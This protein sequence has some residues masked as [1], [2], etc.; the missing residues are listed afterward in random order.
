MGSSS[1][2][3]LIEFCR[4]NFK[5]S[6]TTTAS[7]R[8]FSAHTMI[9]EEKVM[10]GVCGEIRIGQVLWYLELGGRVGFNPYIKFL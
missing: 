10:F 5:L 6:Y 2:T 4:T 9:F 1:W 8:K 7:F 3:F